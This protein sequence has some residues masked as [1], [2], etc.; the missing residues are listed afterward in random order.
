VL[1]GDDR[2]DLDD[3]LPGFSLTVNQLFATSAPDE[4]PTSAGEAGE[5]ET[6][7]S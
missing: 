4:V 1:R 2:I 7:A 6:P 3:V 5:N